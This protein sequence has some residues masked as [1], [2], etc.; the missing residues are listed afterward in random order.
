MCGLFWHD[1]SSEVTCKILSRPLYL[2]RLP[3]LFRLFDLA[4]GHHNSNALVDCKH[5]KSVSLCGSDQV[6]CLLKGLIM[7][8]ARVIHL[9]IIGRHIMPAKPLSFPH[10]FP[11]VM[12]TPSVPNGLPD[13]RS[14]CTSDARFR[15][16]VDTSQSLKKCPHSFITFGRLR[17]LTFTRLQDLERAAHKPITK[18]AKSC[19]ITSRVRQ[20]I[21]LA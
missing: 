17:Q 16:S 11:D 21:S 7:T 6:Y 4:E 10:W 8:V 15:H 12:P 19:A 13:S 3:F 1:C 2:Q 20:V 9:S 18:D 14:S 5:W